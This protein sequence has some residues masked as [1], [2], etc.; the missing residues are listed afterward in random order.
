[1]DY[2]Q[3]KPEQK[4]TAEEL[5]YDLNSLY[6]YLSKIEDPRS[7]FGRQYPLILLLIWILL[8]KLAGQDKP[9]GIAEW[10]AHRIDLWVAYHLTPK[11]K[12]PSHMTYRRIL[13]SV[14]SVEELEA[15]L[16]KYHHSQLEEGQEI[17]L[18]MDGKTVRG[19][20]PAGECRG[21][22][23]L[24]IYV[25][26]QGLVLAEA[27]VDRKENEIVVAPQVLSQVNLAGR[28]LIADA[29]HTQK[30]LCRQVVAGAGD[31]V[32]SAK[33]NQARTHWA[34]EKL[35]LPE[36]CN[37]QKGAPLSK[38]FRMAIQVQKGHGRLEKRT[39]LT[40]AGLNEY[41]QIWPGLAQVFRIETIIWHGNLYTRH[42][43]YGFTSL[44]PAR[45]APERILELLA[46]YWGIENG[47]HYRRDVTLLEDATRLT[48]GDAGQVMA[49]L[50]NFVIGLCLAHH[51]NLASA[52]RLFD[53]QP[54]RALDLL[55]SANP[56]TL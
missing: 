6:D 27:A 13:Q 42:L 22:H 24:A 35:F 18:S 41:L 10:V 14:L 36:V 43:R 34:I 29:L 39:I 49:I 4:E 56:K 40:S 45:A 19:T 37:L 23:L 25:P 51:K 12:A 5:I 9:S 50:N 21:T 26:Q 44:S 38:E 32:L 55:L 7:R 31:Y 30:E 28:I 1:M 17:I 16:V 33:E 48:V 2:T 20:I 11:P 15:L 3:G 46:T 52:R 47:L 8:A 53:A 54:K